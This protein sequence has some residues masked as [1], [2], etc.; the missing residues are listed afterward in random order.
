MC[1]QSAFSAA[2]SLSF[3]RKPPSHPKSLLLG[4]KWSKNGA[5]VTGCYADNTG[6][7]INSF[8]TSTECPP[9]TS[10]EQLHSDAYTRPS[11]SP[12]DSLWPPS[13]DGQSK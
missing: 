7:F 6:H 5:T 9:W 13:G 4:A 3:L 10:S 2:L 1:P 8:H 12:G 11:P